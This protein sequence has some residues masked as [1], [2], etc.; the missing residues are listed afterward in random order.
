MFF[1]DETCELRA[2]KPVRKAAGGNDYEISS[3]HSMLPFQ[4][5]G[6]NVFVIF[7]VKLDIIA[8][9]LV[10]T[11]HTCTRQRKLTIRGLLQCVRY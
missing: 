7:K 3:I 5:Y 4:L 8:A 6:G 11:M 9:E 2:N 1:L 10:N